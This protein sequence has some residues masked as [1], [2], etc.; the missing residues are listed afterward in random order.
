MLH[1]YKSNEESNNIR[2]ADSFDPDKHKTEVRINLA[3]SNARLKE[4]E[5]EYA[6]E[7][8]I[9]DELHEKLYKIYKYDRIQELKKEFNGKLPNKKNQIEMYY[10]QGKS[11]EEIALLTDSK[12]DY[13][14]KVICIYKKLNDK[15]E[16]KSELTEKETL[17]LEAGK[18]SNMTVS[19]ISLSFGCSR[20]YVYKI[21]KENNVPYIRK[22]K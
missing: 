12:L 3:K 13:I 7:K 2:F 16:L 10:A 18:F 20:Q 22:K 19:Q 21:L 11:Y 4:L 5:T 9:N 8:E 14:Y 6:K 15:Y 17:I 1:T